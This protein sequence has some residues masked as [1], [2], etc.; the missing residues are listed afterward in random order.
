MENGSQV[1]LVYTNFAKSFDTVLTIDSKADSKTQ[2][3]RKLNSYGLQGKILDWM[4]KL[5]LNR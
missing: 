4:E 2:K 1:N 3:T 5:L